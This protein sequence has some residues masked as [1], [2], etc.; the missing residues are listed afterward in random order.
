MAGR[1]VSIPRISPLE[2]GDK[3]QETV[4]TLRILSEISLD[5][6]SV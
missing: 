4:I 2:K 1:W 6:I 3:R 5:E